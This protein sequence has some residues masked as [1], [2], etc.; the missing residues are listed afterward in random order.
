MKREAFAQT[1][2]ILC[3]G[4]EDSALARALTDFSPRKLTRSDVSPNN[5]VGS[6]SG[7]TE[8]EKAIIGAEITRGFEKV[9]HVV[10]VADNDDNPIDSFNQVT[11]QLKKAKDEGSV[12]RD[13]AIPAQPGVKTAG[14]PSVTIWMWP[15]IGQPGC[16]ESLLWKI[17]ETEY[18]PISLC[19]EAALQCS[20]AR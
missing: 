11:L 12:K 6:V 5:D 13:W 16:L 19:V 9:Q 7:N 4:F 15:S 3:E 1:R 10:V 17:I 20:G 8:F 18:Q 14:D 2:F